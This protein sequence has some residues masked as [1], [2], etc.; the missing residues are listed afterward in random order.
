MK[1]KLIAIVLGLS[2]AFG[3]YTSIDS[4]ALYKESGKVTLSKIDRPDGVH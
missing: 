3:S 1:K 4:G 2:I